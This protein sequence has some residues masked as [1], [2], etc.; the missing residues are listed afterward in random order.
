MG[1]VLNVQLLVSVSKNSDFRIWFN[2]FQESFVL[3]ILNGYGVLF[4]VLFYIFNEFKFFTS[5]NKDCLDSKVHG[6]QTS[7]QVTQ[8]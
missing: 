3:I 1:N 2:D 4:I 6:I 7:T 5:N 8:V